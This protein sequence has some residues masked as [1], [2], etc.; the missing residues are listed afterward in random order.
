MAK[1]EIP[2]QE[3]QN[4]YAWGAKQLRASLKAKK[5]P[6]FTSMIVQRFSVGLIGEAVVLFVPLLIAAVYLDLHNHA[7][8]GNLIILGFV[9]SCVIWFS[10]TIRAVTLLQKLEGTRDGDFK[11]KQQLLH[12]L[13][14][15]LP[16]AYSVLLVVAG[17]LRFVD[18][19]TLA[20]V[21]TGLVMVG[22]GVAF[23]R[24]AKLYQELV[25]RIST[26]DFHRVI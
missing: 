26:S 1:A 9:V 15:M 23:Y 18:G 2:S 25:I 16:L 12:L 11:P 5:K 8:V 3:Q 20:N 14:V 22:C 17:I 24:Y 6:E 7:L 19:F 13:L 10:E 21:L 4:L